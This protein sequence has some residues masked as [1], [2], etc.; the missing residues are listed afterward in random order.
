MSELAF[1]YLGTY[2]TAPFFAMIRMSKYR[3]FVENKIGKQNNEEFQKKSAKST[4]NHKFIQQES[5]CKQL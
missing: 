1:L 2:F 3:I 4:K 5:E